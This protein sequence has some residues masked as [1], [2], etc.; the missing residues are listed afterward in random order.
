MATEDYEYA[1]MVPLKVTR[2]ITNL[3]QEIQAAIILTN[4]ELTIRDE[5]W[6][7]FDDVTKNYTFTDVDEMDETEIMRTQ[8]DMNMI[9]NELGDGQKLQSWTGF[10][11]AYNRRSRR[12]WNVYSDLV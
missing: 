6:S 10:D 1:Q 4:S 11:D 3:M 7:P 8:A 5:I 12:P 9:T 2:P